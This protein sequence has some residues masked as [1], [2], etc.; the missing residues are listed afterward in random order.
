MD[1]ELITQVG[2]LDLRDVPLAQLSTMQ[3][4]LVAGMIDELIREVTGATNT[5]IIAFN[6]EIGEQECFSPSTSSY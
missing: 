1:N 5:K 2:V 6:S 4:D 3:P